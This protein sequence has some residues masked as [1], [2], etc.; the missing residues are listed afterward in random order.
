MAKFE[1]GDRVECL[2]HAPEDNTRITIGS[3]G[4][5]CRGETPRGQFGVRWDDDVHGNSCGGTC[6]YG[7]GW[8]IDSDW[9]ELHEEKEIDIEESSFI[10]MLG[11]TK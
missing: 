6:A 7:H 2:V 5:V 4:T 10:N 11:G 3:V 1:I 8:F 9:I